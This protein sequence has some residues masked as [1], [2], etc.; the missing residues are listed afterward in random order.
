[1]KK[2]NYVLMAVL[3]FVI[4]TCLQ[5]QDEE[6]EIKPIAG[7]SYGGFGIFNERFGNVYDDYNNPVEITFGAGASRIYV[8][9][10]Y[11]NF[12]SGHTYPIKNYAFEGKA[13][14]DSDYLSF[15]VRFFSSDSS[16]LRF[17]IDLEA[18]HVSV[19]EKIGTIDNNPNLR[20]EVNMGK[21]GF[22]VGI[23]LNVMFSEYFGLNTSLEF[24]S[25]KTDIEEKYLDGTVNLGG[26]YPSIGIIIMP[27]GM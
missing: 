26:I 3:F 4:V 20:G 10:K 5:A 23:G 19:T 17:Y 6:F 18:A 25:I 27:L 8:V 12:S 7:I 24:I 2:T 11:K 13:D 1:M 15:G 9:G 21:W 16:K 14:Y 22:G